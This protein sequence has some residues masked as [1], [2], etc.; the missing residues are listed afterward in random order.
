[1]DEIVLQNTRKYAKYNIVRRVENPLNRV[2]LDKKEIY[3]VNDVEQEVLWRAVLV[4]GMTQSRKTQKCF[5]LLRQ[6]I[7]LD[8]NNVLVLFVTQ[9][10]NSASVEQLIQRAK[11]SKDI[12]KIIRSDNIFR[13]NETPI[14]GII[15]ENK[16]IVDFWKSSNM[17]NMIDF[18]KVNHISFKSIIIIIDECDQ[19]DLVGT[20]NR[21]LFIRDIE[22][23]APESII[24]VIFMTATIANL[25][26]NIC[27]IAAYNLKK[28]QNGI[29]NEII[30]KPVV[31]HCFVTPHESY[32]PPSYFQDNQDILRKISFPKRN[33]DATVEEYRNSNKNIVFKEIKALPDSAKELAL[34][35]LSSCTEIHSEIAIRLLNCGF[36]VS[37]EMN[38]TNNKDFKVNFINK[39]GTISTWNIPYKKLDD[40][41]DNGDISSYRSNRTIVESNIF[42]KNDYSMPHV[43]QAALFMM[44]DIEDRIIEHANPEELTKLNAIT[45]AIMNMSRTLR[46]PDDYPQSPKIALVV[47]HLASRGVTFQDPS[48]DFTCTSF[49]FADISGSSTVIQRGAPHAQKFGRACGMLSEAFARPGRKP[50]LITTEPILRDALAN[51]KVVRR[52]GDMFPNGTLVCLKDFIPTEEWNSILQSTKKSIRNTESRLI[53][54]IPIEINARAFLGKFDVH[55]VNGIGDIRKLVWPHVIKCL[56][57]NDSNIVCNHNTDNNTQKIIEKIK[58]LKNRSSRYISSD[59]YGDNKP[60]LRAKECME[61]HIGN[62][63]WSD[64]KKVTLMWIGNPPPQRFECGTVYIQCYL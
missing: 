21:L 55:K 49:C 51:E 13:S 6:K 52:K 30:H 64:D 54:I 48:I 40:M 19:G 57:S 8:E 34:I 14:E 35:C 43:L 29:V 44:T 60:A 4:D 27:K 3:V 38:S 63:Y 47:G 56:E 46:R 20:K 59:K 2:N 41:A 15:H 33:V 11:K 5:E 26:K 7:E 62:H 17:S 53:P 28:F 16:M 37:V 45:N 58:D 12:N 10:N 23:V 18:V 9:A 61:K 36:D 42:D 50:Y 25:S 31:E 39:S 1:M 24:K 32:I 22:Q